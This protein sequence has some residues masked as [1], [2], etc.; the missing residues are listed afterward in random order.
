MYFEILLVF[1][2]IHDEQHFCLPPPQTNPH[3]SFKIS[4]HH[5]IVSV[6]FNV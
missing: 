3:E 6:R 2:L 5:K 4:L 1:H